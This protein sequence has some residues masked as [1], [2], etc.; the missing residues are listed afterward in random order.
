MLGLGA[1]G[2]AAAIEAH[3]AGARRR[4]AREDARGPRGRQHA[5]LRRRLVRQQRPRGH[6][7]LPARPLR[8][9]PGPRGDHPGLGARDGAELGLGRESRRAR[10]PARR[11]PPRVPGAARQRLLRRLH[12][13][14]WR[15]GERAALRRALRG[16]PG[17]R[18]RSAARYAGTRTAAGRL[19]RHRGRRGAERGERGRDAAARAR[20][21]GC[22]ARH[23]GVREQRGDGARLPA[24][25]GLARLGVARRDRRRHP[26]GAAG[27]RRPLAHGQHGDRLRL[28]RAR[29]RERLLRLLPLRARLHLHRH[30]RPA[31]DERVPPERPRS[32][33]AARPL[34]AL[35]GGS[36]CT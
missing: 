6:R 16:R 29:L 10:R 18:H 35:P 26:H 24:V 32:R 7:H 9:V 11:L 17:A 25:A 34:R 31:A 21:T 23:R 15:T 27:G 8:R 28:P 2:C 4:R 12:R 19:G 33:T 30:G 1:A 20:A 3:D 14:R 13:R 36:R 22:R 5:R